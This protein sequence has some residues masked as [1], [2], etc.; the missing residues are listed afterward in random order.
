M[1]HWNK[2]SQWSRGNS[3]LSCLCCMILKNLKTKLNLING[4]ISWKTEFTTCESSS[5]GGFRLKCWRVFPLHSFDNKVRNP[6][7]VFVL[8]VTEKSHSCV[9]HLYDTK[10]RDKEVEALSCYKNPRRGTPIWNR[11]GC[12]SEILNLTPKGNHLGV[13]QRLLTKKK[14]EGK[15]KFNFSFSSRNSVFLRRTLNETLAA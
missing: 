1:F 8:R 7:L 14:K 15:R 9:I 12:S 2:S 6:L 4:N 10:S 13:A 11:R 5:R 3:L